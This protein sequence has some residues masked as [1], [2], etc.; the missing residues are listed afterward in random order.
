MIKLSA[1]CYV[2]EQDERPYA[3]TKKIINF[4]LMSLQIYLAYVII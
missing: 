1:S 3:L 2:R 4:R